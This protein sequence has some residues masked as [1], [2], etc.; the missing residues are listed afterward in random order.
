MVKEEPG[1]CSYCEAVE[2]IEPEHVVSRSI[3]VNDTQST[4]IIPACHHCNNEKSAGEDDLRDYLI[5]RVGVDG[6]PDIYPLMHEMAKAA[7]KG[8]SRIGKAASEERELKLRTLP[9]GMHVPAYE[10]PLP[11]LRHMHRTLRY[12]VRGLHFYEQGTAWTSEMPLSLGYVDDEDFEETVRDLLSLTPNRFRPSLGNDVFKYVPV[13]RPGSPGVTEWLMI[14]FG[15]VAIIG[16]AG[17]AEDE[18]DRKL[19]FAE[20]I[21]RKGTR[22]KALRGIVDRRLVRTAPTDLLGF[23]RQYEERKKKRLR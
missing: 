11:E 10:I 2:P 6:H 20:R 13:S 16:Y 18:K 15:K 7:G 3:F 14:F 12:I 1:V 5:I 21:K 8:F 19:S 17:I 22:E 4:I 23:L 9:S